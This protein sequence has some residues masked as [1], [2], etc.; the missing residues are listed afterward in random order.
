MTEVAEALGVQ[1]DEI[2]QLKQ[3]RDT[4]EESQQV[5]PIVGSQSFILVTSASHMP[6]A[7]G[8][9]RK[10]GL[11]PIPAPTDHLAPRGPLEL[12]DLFPDGYKLFKSRYG[13]GLA[14]P[15]TR[16]ISTGRPDLSTRYCGL[17]L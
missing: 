9:F 4:E 8:L 10:R 2:L 14:F 5:A 1:A 7:M 17:R 12:D 11:Q 15:S 3:P 6:R 13:C 16:K